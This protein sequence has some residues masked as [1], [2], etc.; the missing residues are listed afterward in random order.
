MTN[1]IDRECKLPDFKNKYLNK[2]VIFYELQKM[3]AWVGRLSQSVCL[4]VC[5]SVCPQHNS[6]KFP[7]QIQTWCMEWSWNIL[8]VVWFWDWKVKSQGHRVN[9]CIFTLLHAAKL[10]NEWSQIWPLTFQSKSM[11]LLAFSMVI[12]CTKFENVGIIQFLF[13]CC[14]QT[15]NQTNRLTD[16]KNPTHADR[17]SRRG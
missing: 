11:S 8:E 10:K 7:K 1:G 12:P 17:Q 14:G 16:S 4:S 13:L 15:N 3:S 6:R 2:F 9:K 5:L